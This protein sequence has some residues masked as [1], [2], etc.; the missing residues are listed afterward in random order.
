MPG[1]TEVDRKFHVAS[2]I[3][4]F[5]IK[6]DGTKNSFPVMSGGIP[7][8]ETFHFRDLSFVVRPGDPVTPVHFEQRC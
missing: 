6:V 1:N 8:L 4:N 5:V 7:F 3:E 2:K